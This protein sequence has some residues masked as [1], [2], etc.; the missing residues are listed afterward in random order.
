M[1]NWNIISAV[2]T[3]LSAVATV[4]AVILTMVQLKTQRKQQIAI[5]ERQREDD[6]KKR[7]TEEKT[8]WSEKINQAS[9]ISGWIEREKILHVI[10]LSDAPVY[11]VV[12]SYGYIRGAAPEQVDEGEFIGTLPNG[13]Y[14]VDYNH[15]IDL[16]MGKVPEI[17]IWFRDVRGNF[18]KRKADGKLVQQY[19]NAALTGKVINQPYHPVVITKI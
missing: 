5:M 10:N 9:K 13:E 14:T 4:F 19:A 6:K 15:H 16:D 1:I 17:I 18:W 3:F 8:L 11:D 7:E 12:V 2:G